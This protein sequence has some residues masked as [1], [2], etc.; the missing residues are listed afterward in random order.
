MMRWLLTVTTF[1]V[2]LGGIADVQAVT[3]APDPSKKIL[4][5]VWGI[6]PV[7]DNLV[8]SNSSTFDG[9]DITDTDWRVQAFRRNP[10]A[11]KYSHI[12]SC[13]IDFVMR[14]YPNVM[15]Q[16]S[17]DLVKR[18]AEG[19]GLYYIP[20]FTGICYGGTTQ[21]P[22]DTIDDVLSRF[23]D[24]YSNEMMAWYL[25]D[26]LNPSVNTTNQV[27]ANDLLLRNRIVANDDSI[28]K[29]GVFTYVGGFDGCAAIDINQGEAH[30]LSALYNNRT[31]Q[32]LSGP[33]VHSVYYYR[34][35]YGGLGYPIQWIDER[36]K[37]LFD[38]RQQ[39]CSTTNTTIDK[40]P[41]WS[42]V[43]A[44][45]EP[46]YDG[47][48]ID[49]TFVGVPNE[50]SLRMEVFT[51]LA[52][53][54]KGI[55][56]LTYSYCAEPGHEMWGMDDLS[57]AFNGVFRGTLYNNQYYYPTPGNWQN[58]IYGWMQNVNAEVHTIA[59]ALGEVTHYEPVVTYDPITT[60]DD[61]DFA[62]SSHFIS[63]VTH[64]GTPSKS[65]CVIATPFVNTSTTSHQGDYLLVVNQSEITYPRPEVA[66]N[67]RDVVITLNSTNLDCDGDGYSDGDGIYKLTNLLGDDR[68][69]VQIG[70]AGNPS[71][72]TMHLE[73]GEAKFFRIEKWTP[74]SFTIAENEAYYIQP[75]TAIKFP[76]G[77][78][79]IVYGELTANNA[80]FT[81]Q[82]GVSTW[83][84]WP[85]G[86]RVGT[87]GTGGGTPNVTLTN[88]TIEYCYDSGIAC[89]DGTT[90][91]T[92]CTIRYNGDHG[93][94]ANVSAGGIVRING[95][96]IHNNTLCGALI[97]NTSSTSYVKGVSIHHNNDTGLSV[98]NTNMPIGESGTWSN[99][100]Y[101]NAS[102]ANGGVY[103][104]NFSG[105]FQRNRVYS[106]S[107][108]GVYVD[109]GDDSQIDYNNIHGN[110]SYDLVIDH[111]ANTYLQDNWL[112]GA[113]SSEIRLGH[114]S[115]CHIGN[116]PDAGS[117]NIHEN[118]YGTSPTGSAQWA[119]AWMSSSD[120]S[121]IWGAHQNWWGN[122]NP[123]AANIFQYPAKVT[124][125][126][127]LSSRTRWNYYPRAARR[128]PN[129]LSVAESMS[130]EDRAAFDLMNQAKTSER[131]TSAAIYRSV[132]E[133][134]AG[135]SFAPRAL[136][137]LIVSMA[138]N[139]TSED[140]AREY[141]ASL[142]EQEPGADLL[143][144]VNQLEDKLPLLFKNY[145]G[146]LE[147]AQRQARQATDASS[148][149]SALADVA[150]LAAHTGDMTL[151]RRAHAQVQALGDTT[152]VARMLGY[153][154]DNPAGAENN[155][156]DDSAVSQVNGLQA[157]PNP[158]NP[159]TTL[160]YSVETPGNVQLTVFNA[161]G[162]LVRTLVNTEATAGTHSVVWNGR[163]DSGRRVASGV[164]LV[165]L[166][167][168]TQT[169]TTRVTMVY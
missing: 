45:R 144:R 68:Y 135:S 18:A 117:N 127:P 103:L 40:Y 126:T 136:G 27:A 166:I 70:G 113:T 153:I 108:W 17:E 54:A 62:S 164:Y 97:M 67:A 95:G 163:D 10:D 41:F 112:Y 125:Y 20:R 65:C 167:T 86:I 22:Q 28:A 46:T 84:P 11:H 132:V 104:R 39:H 25:S 59:D 12:K 2:F 64:D 150:W 73:S 154:L 6:P 149:Q 26:D 128:D 91:L 24:Q 42:A 51:H 102:S 19:A 81:R 157:S 43:Y 85:A 133:N 131:S 148:R 31:R 107:G 105:T 83:G 36:L 145:E 89:Y 71:Q 155:E 123:T 156:G 169:H 47:N 53:G 74:S 55:L 4:I 9:F 159:T 7:P 137:K 120:A 161:A 162:Q 109:E 93:V 72:V 142:R 16:D 94:A 1:L 57:E 98:W 129:A 14:N 101:S 168:Q 75:G 5:G 139:N 79:I 152:V 61:I 106:N 143:A 60:P 92:N 48:S 23:A 8:Y 158:F 140:E 121:N 63:S 49:D 151:S 165:R 30:L 78:G 33:P 15:S 35:R 119:V 141:L 114:S 116:D 77:H 34:H 88:C 111:Y 118:D 29:R 130:A 21:F 66:G 37:K 124:F 160:H 134:Y 3:S 13:G 44:T 122:A 100:I 147:V 69:L 76:S 52:W 50:A 90:T 99:T 96:S 38:I 146:A 80:V 138:Q 115:T 58:D 56:Y 32:A 110:G 87:Y 82:Q